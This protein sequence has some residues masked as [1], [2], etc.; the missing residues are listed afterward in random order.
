VRIVHVGKRLVGEGQPC[1]LVAEVG[2]NHNGD[3]ALAHRCIDA[4]ADVGADALK[5]QNYRTEDFLSDRSLTY[6][7]VSQGKKVIESQYDMFKRCE[8]TPAALLELREHCERRGVVFFSTPSSIDGVADLVRVGVPILKNS[9]DCLM[10]LPLIRAMAR[11]GIPTVLSTGMAAVA[12]TADAVRVFRE[13]GGKELILLHCTS[14]YPTPASDV[15]LRKIPTL[16][17]TFG[18]PAGLSDHTRGIVAAVGAAALGACLIEKHFTLDKNLPGPDH[19]F[20]ADPSEFRSLVEGVR[21]IEQSL[22]DPALGFTESERQARMDY[23]LSC[24]AARALN[25]GD[26]LDESDVAF[27]RPGTG[28][29]PALSDWLVGRRLRHAVDAGHMFGLEDVE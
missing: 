4:A 22:G 28:F 21:T 10:H 29:P 6:E 8:L 15:H 19:W 23:R 26:T 17:A 20:S 5:F 1:F 7:Y 3:M 18:C 12:D 25:K 14:S 2:I 13:A 11:T 24:V 9:S 27:H 16:A